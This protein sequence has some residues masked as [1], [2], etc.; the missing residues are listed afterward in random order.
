MINNLQYMNIPLT[1]QEIKEHFPN[2][3]VGLDVIAYKDANECNIK[4]AKVLCT[5]TSDELLW[6]Q[7]HGEIN[8]SRCTIP[9]GLQVGVFI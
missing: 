6:K 2:T 1:W 7:I 4:T 5:G 3:W 8:D 9:D